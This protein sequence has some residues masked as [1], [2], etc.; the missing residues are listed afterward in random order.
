M[1]PDARIRCDFQASNCFR[2][3]ARRMH[4][5]MMVRVGLECPLVGKTELLATN[6]F[7]RLGVGYA[8]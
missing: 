1:Q 8:R 4:R 3:S 7:G 2:R 5:A 6:R